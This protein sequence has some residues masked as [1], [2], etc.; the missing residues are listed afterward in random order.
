MKVGLLT[1]L[2]RTEEKLIIQALDDR[3]VNYE[4]IDVRQAVFNLNDACGWRDY[5]VIFDRCVSQSQAATALGVFGYWG[6]PCVNQADVVE[7]CGD[8]RKTTQALVAAGVPTPQTRLA[9]TPESALQAIEEMSY[10]VVLKPLVGSWGRLLAKVNDREAAE[11]LLE[12]K[13]VLGSY[14]HNIFYIQE[15]IQKNGRDIRSFVVGGET[16]CAITRSSEHWI[17][18]TAK[19]GKADNC[20]LTPEIEK[21]SC[22]AAAAVGGGILAVDLF[23][24]SD[25][26][27]LVNEVNHTM[28][29]RNS[30]KPTGVDIPGRM[31]DY[32]LEVANH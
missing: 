20:P 26:R 24:S 9:L 14:N 3:K 25:G 17:T 4:R 21:L 32:V 5:D 7:V 10:P 1:T 23:E 29:F 19:G 28:E 31:I 15:Y 16:I 27:L 8:K 13:A 2:I 12:H 22:Q 6:I 11:A 30:I 18:N